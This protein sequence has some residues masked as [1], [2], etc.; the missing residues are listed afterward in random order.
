MN[1]MKNI[2]NAFK[3]ILL[4]EEQTDNFQEKIDNL[5]AW[6]L[7]DDGQAASQTAIDAAKARITAYKEA[8]ESTFIC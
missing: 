7:S 4:Y 6:L 2:S 3:N 8:L 5:N 1:M